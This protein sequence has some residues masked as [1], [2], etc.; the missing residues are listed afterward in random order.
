MKTTGSI[1]TLL[2]E[3]ATRADITDIEEPDAREGES[4][5][6]EPANE[7]LENGVERSLLGN[8]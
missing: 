5:L 8:L 6:D 3:R 2:A 4:L 1:R 7:P